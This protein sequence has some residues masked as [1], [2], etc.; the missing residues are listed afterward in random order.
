MPHRVMIVEDDEPFRF[1]AERY[2]RAAGYDVIGAADSMAALDALDHGVA[3]DLIITDI[4]MPEGKP[5]GLALARMARLRRK[6]PC[7]FITG[8]QELVTAE[9]TLPGRVFQKPVDFAA[10]VNEVQLC[11]AEAPAESR[12]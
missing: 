11:L 6:V 5:H 12:A 3:V 9:A 10:L 8:Y 1:A 2:L 7:I 4:V